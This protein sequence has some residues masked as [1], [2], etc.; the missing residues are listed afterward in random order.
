MCKVNY[1]KEKNGIEISFESKPSTETRTE[2]KENGFRWSKFGGFWY[3]KQK[4]STIAI[5]EKLSGG[6]PT[7][8]QENLFDMLQFGNIADPNYKG[9]GY[10]GIN[11]FG[12]DVTEINKKIRMDLKRFKGF[13]FSIKKNHSSSI[14]IEILEGY[15]QKDSKEFKLLEKYI[16]DLANSYNYDHSDLYSDY[17]SS[18]F[19]LSIYTNNYIEKAPTP[20]QAKDIEVLYLA[21]AEKEE[22]ER[23]KQEEDRKQREIERE[24]EKLA[25]EKRQIEKD[26]ERKILL[27]TVEVKPLE[28]G[29]QY[30]VKGVTVPSLNKLCT[31]TE[32][33]ETM[34]EYGSDIMDFKIVKEV[35]FTS[36]TLAYYENM[37]MDSFDFLTGEG[38]SYTDDPRINSMLDFQHLTQEEQKEI[39]W[40]GVGVA[41]YCNK[42]LKYIADPSGHDYTRYLGL[43]DG[44]TIAPYEPK[45]EQEPTKQKLHAMAIEDYSTSII[46]ENEIK[47]FED[48]DQYDQLLLEKMKENNIPLTKEVIQQ[49]TIESLKYK[50]YKLYYHIDPL[51]EQFNKAEFK[52]GEKITI[53]SLGMGI[54]SEQ[55]TYLSHKN[56]TYAQYT[57]VVKVVL[58]LP[59]KKHLRECT[60][61][62]ETVIVKGNVEVPQD[63]NSHETEDNG[64]FRSTMSNYGCFDKRYW[65]DLIQWLQEQ[66]IEIIVNTVKKQ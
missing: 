55:C 41:I 19:Y 15:F 39:K 43:C 30:L 60:L 10:Q 22:Q 45:Q 12:Y 42:E 65:Y 8:P 53:F 47:N 17:H 66:G 9:Q 16:K 7:T 18:N 61:H 52:E 56:S 21:I 25:Y 64:V 59:R 23:I 3:A 51:Q 31:V 35:H 34:E 33:R 5:A 24:Q 63:I 62:G 58:K 28:E 27:D 29:E 38:G 32:Y 40:I 14:H 46:T 49:T 20:Q 2:L 11:F 26:K 13:K 37:L 48:S 4:P 6:T 57:D 44:V 50:L 54:S 36:E 1:N